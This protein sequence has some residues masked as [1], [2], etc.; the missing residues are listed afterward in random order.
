MSVNQMS[1]RAESHGVGASIRLLGTFAMIGA[2]FLCL[3]FI[4]VGLT[5]DGTQPPN[6]IV[7]ALELLYLGGWLASAVGLR[8]LKATGEGAL[9]GTIF[10]IQLAGLTLAAL[11]TVQGIV[12]ADPDPNR[13]FFRVTDAA[14]PLSH[15]FMLVV[16]AFVLKAKV[17]RG[18]RQFTPILCGLALPS[19]FAANALFGN[20]IGGIVF[21]LGTVATFM[22][23]GYAVRTSEKAS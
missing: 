18:W 11:F 4:L 8:Q 3:E 7:G 13:L 9:A 23:L 17:W 1:L 5:F 12:Q 6:R 14:W 20:K 19:L 16:G 22:L 2:P 21:G 10:I 15:L